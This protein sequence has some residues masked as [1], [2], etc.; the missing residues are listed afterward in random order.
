MRWLLSAWLLG[1]LTH[2]TAAASP[3]T[4][5]RST[6][7]PLGFQGSLLAIASDG[8]KA[9]LV[10]FY[11]VYAADPSGRSL[12]SVATLGEL[13]NIAWANGLWVVVGNAGNLQTS[14]DG[15]EWTKRLTGT[16]SALK[17]VAG[18]TGGWIVCEEGTGFYLF[19]SDG[20]SWDRR[21]FGS[22]FYPIAL[23]WGGGHWLASSTTGML[24]SAD[25]LN[26][27][28]ATGE[29]AW[30]RTLAWSGT[31]WLGV[32]NLGTP[33]TSPDGLE[34]T[35]EAGSLTF[36]QT[37]AAAG[38]VAVVSGAFGRIYRSSANG[39]WSPIASPIEVVVQDLEWTGQAFVGVGD[40]G[41]VISSRDGS[42]WELSRLA[43]GDAFV[44]L[45]SGPTQTLAVTTGGYAF[46][47]ADG[48]DWQPRP[49]IQDLAV[50]DMVWTGDDYVAV[51]SSRIWSSPDGESWS[52]V[53]PP[54]GVQLR[55][56]TSNGHTTIAVGD[57]GVVAARQSSGNWASLANQGTS[58]LVDV[59]CGG[60]GFLAV[61]SAGQT[62][63]STDGLT[64]EP[65][66]A[67]VPL[68]ALTR[69]PTHFIGV[70]TDG[71]VLQ[72]VDGSVWS[73]LLE[74]A[75]QSFSTAAGT[76]GALV[77]AG[78]SSLYV[79]EGDGNWVT[80][81]SPGNLTKLLADRHVFVGVG[82]YG[83][84]AQSPDGASWTARLPTQG[85][86]GGPIAWGNGRFV[87]SG[88]QTS[89]NGESWTTR[90][91]PNGSS[92]QNICFSETGFMA[93][94]EGG[95]VCHSVDGLDWTASTVPGAPYLLQVKPFLGGYLAMGSAGAIAKYNPV[96]GWSTGTLTG[97]SGNASVVSLA[98]SPSLAVCVTFGNQVF[99]SPD[100]LSWTF[101]KNGMTNV[102]WDGT[103]FIASGTTTTSVSADGAVWVNQDPAVWPTGTW[104]GCFDGVY[105]VRK[106]GLTLRVGSPVGGWTDVAVSDSSNSAAYDGSAVV[107]GGLI[108][109][110][111]SRKSF[112]EWAAA[113]GIAGDSS[114]LVAD[115]NGDGT[116]NG[117]AFLFGAPN[118][119]A[120]VS[121]G[122]APA[123]GPG[124]TPG[125]AR[126]VFSS[127]WPPAEDVVESVWYARDLGSGWTKV[128]ERSAQGW[129]SV[130]PGV[131]GT[132]LGAES[133]RTITLDVPDAGGSARGFFRLG[134][135]HRDDTSP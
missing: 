37:V 8:H 10:D 120:V 83:L 18:G 15:D 65:G 111:S 129:M 121:G 5:W 105:I 86:G 42:H 60:S 19:S 38:G 20:V 51:S 97:T 102:V 67:T 77:V 87:R 35:P 64:W 101:R 92:L 128:A 36:G 131:T 95:K 132:V 61:S 79:K 49:R 110:G 56:I 32:N 85:G 33:V 11:H 91:I 55:A 50:R 41:A 81:T 90:R 96:S 53:Y 47:S 127:A 63:R 130:V 59:E 44:A 14:T 9:R 27:T 62:F 72:T 103:R 46:S 43:T 100:G 68:S 71:K 98:T 75:G 3:W 39:V 106:S 34:W 73:T 25:G 45:A 122:W 70:S 114:G 113:S 93:V 23:A 78:W 117:L 58:R 82:N 6:N 119:S 108:S 57:S 135:T 133:L 125:T 12:T 4:Q 24:R 126:T 2:A 118:A 22:S 52:F 123:C 40:Q 116:A 74:A 29:V 88:G 109:G 26:W 31:R 69:T 1:A 89:V 115:Q 54:G 134:V 104:I 124:P 13:W 112:A 17:L 66:A 99:S 16:G 7:G 30:V 84:L 76:S 107:L 21:E 28:P 48:L 94:G 80:Q